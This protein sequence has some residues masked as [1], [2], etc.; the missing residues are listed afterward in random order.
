MRLDDTIA[1]IATAQQPSGLGVIRISGPKALAAAELIFR[2]S[3][4]VALSEA[5]SHQFRHGWIADA[6]GGVDEGRLKKAEW[7]ARLA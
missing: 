5:P 6:E 2:S 4:A 3:G 7:L 1:A